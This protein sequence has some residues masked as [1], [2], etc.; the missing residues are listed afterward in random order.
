MDGKTNGGAAD[1][2]I[3]VPAYNEAGGI[4]AAIQGIQDM[5]EKSDRSYELIVVDDGSTDGTADLAEKTGA[6]VYRHRRNKGY[7]AAL[8]TGVLEARGEY[9]VFFDADN[10]FDPMDIERVMDRARGIEA[11]FGSRTSKS[12]APFSRKGGKK[13]LGLLANYLAR[14]R[15]PDLNCGLRAIKRDVLLEYLHL[16]PNGFSASTTTTLIILR[17][18]Y[19]VDFVPITVKKRVGKSTVRPLRDGMDTVLLVLR[20][21]TLLDP[22]RVFGPASIF[23]FLFGVAWGLRYLLM[24]R[25]LSM[26]SLFLLVSS[27]MV[28]FFGLLAD[29]ISSLRRERRYTERKQP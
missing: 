14:M 27:V 20:L 22:F 15:I 17:E 21:T 10:Q 11:A 5:M 19:E 29:Q 1:A 18:G 8:K 12:Y 9:V 25:G 23:L 7:G 24:G 3:I 13:L 4:E 6:V 28:F 26:A 2:S 16:L